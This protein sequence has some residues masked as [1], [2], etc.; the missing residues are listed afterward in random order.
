MLLI[1]VAMEVAEHSIPLSKMLLQLNG[2]A[3]AENLL[4]C[5]TCAS[6]IKHLSMKDN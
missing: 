6:Y 5:R 1:S 4:V 2:T 3:I